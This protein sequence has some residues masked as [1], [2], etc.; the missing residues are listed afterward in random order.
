[1]SQ[2]HA[3]TN[4]LRLRPIE[5]TSLRYVIEE[6]TRLCLRRWLAQGLQSG[7]VQKDVS[8]LDLMGEAE[9]VSWV[10]RRK[11]PAGH[12]ESLDGEIEAFN[13]VLRDRLNRETLHIDTQGQ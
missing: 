2:L 12:I 13:E 7:R 3:E 9:A 11:P 8:R 4:L 1:M 5:P 6:R 10:L